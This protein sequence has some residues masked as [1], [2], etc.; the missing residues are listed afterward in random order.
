MSVILVIEDDPTINE[1]LEYNLRREGFSVVVATS[2]LDGIK[3]ATACQPDLVLLDIMLPGLDGFKVCG[4]LRKD[5]PVLPILMVTA[6][7]DEE[8]MIKGFKSGADDYITKPFSIV[9]IIAKIKAI[10][11][12][13]QALRL[14]Q[15]SRVIA[16][17]DLVI[18]PANYTV[19]VGGQPV[20]LRPKEFQLLSLLASRP[21]Q[22]L[23]RQEIAEKVW[24]YT[25]V[26]GR[27]IDV[28][29]KRIRAKVESLSI[30]SYIKT[31][32][33]LGYRFEDSG[34]A[35]ED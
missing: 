25:A 17:G 26:A 11:R 4:E 3:M 30:A 23:T 10:M 27:T 1:L 12:R 8:N 7:Q 31:V 21:G 2:G 34:A 16:I 35:D 15:G 20:Q 6:L 14:R 33:G 18:D 32:H 5:D 28:H 9:E 29:I 24:G 13:T 19:E 22:L